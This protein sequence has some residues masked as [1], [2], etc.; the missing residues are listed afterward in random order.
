VAGAAAD[1]AVARNV[2][3]EDIR[4]PL[5]DSWKMLAFASLGAPV[6]EIRQAVEAILG[7]QLRDGRYKIGWSP[8]DLGSVEIGR[9]RPGGAHLTRA[10]IF[11]PRTIG[12]T[13][14]LVA[15]LQDGW[16]TLIHVL[17]KRL[18]C[19]GLRIQ[20]STADV[21]YPINSI[22]VYEGGQE[23]R[24]VRAMLDGDRWEF[25]QHGAAKAF[26]S[27]T[28]YRRR[29]VRDRLDRVILIDYLAAL[30]FDITDDQ[31]WSSDRPALLIEEIRP[32]GT[33]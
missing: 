24:T 2:A 19:D 25:F 28:N 26:E 17:C 27:E 10:T 20:T 6:E 23:T 33:G 13:G 4:M 8:L 12:Q 15:N 16:H 29:H 11:K 32:D 31:F 1:R 9:P 21:R 7:D 18:R 14:I 30:G 3:S 5:I 22:T